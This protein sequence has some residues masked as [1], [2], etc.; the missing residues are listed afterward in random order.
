MP[1]LYNL[2]Q[3]SLSKRSFTNQINFTYAN[4]TFSISPKYTYYKFDGIAYYDANVDY[5]VMH[6]LQFMKMGPVFSFDL[7]KM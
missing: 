2:C 4:Y 7:A 3:L 5:A 6:T 1:L